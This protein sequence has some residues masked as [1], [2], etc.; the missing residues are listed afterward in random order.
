MKRWLRRTA[1][2]VVVALVG[3]TVWVVGQREYIRR[4]GESAFAASAAD[5]EATD[6][7]WRWDDLAAKRPRPPEGRNGMDV[8]MRAREALPLDWTTQPLPDAW[9]PLDTPDPPTAKLDPKVAAAARER[10]DA[11]GAGLVL[12]RS[13]KDCPTGLYPLVLADPP[14][15]T[16]F[17]HV[18]AARLV[19]VFLRWDAAVA[20][21]SGDAAAALDRCAAQLN[22]SRALGDDPFMIGQL[23]RVQTRATAW[24]A[25]ERVLA[26]TTSD[27]ARLAAL[28]AAWAAD[29][30]EPLLLFAARGERAISDRT[31]ENMI[32]G[33]TKPDPRDF[34][35]TWFGS[36]SWWLAR[37][38]M[39]PDRAALHEHMSKVVAAA[40]RPV[41]EQPAAFA[42]LPPPP[43]ERQIA[44]LLAPPLDRLA[45]PY[46]RS[47][48]QARCVVVALA[49]ERYR[50]RTGRWPDALG[51]LPP[52]LL[53]AV[54]LDP[55][56]G[57]PLR[58]RRTA[59]GVVVYTVG[60]DRRD[61]GGDVAGADGPD[62][63]F[64]LWN[65][66]LRGQ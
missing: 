9:P 1:A 49:C 43:A 33:V 18:E 29:A 20:A 32:T 37:G 41:H 25:L 36:Y 23:V 7:D 17:P 31:I 55:L 27:P 38:K 3:R 15:S 26:Q 10:L 28:Q 12:A 2:L 24:R 11:G 16:R 4:G 64:R 34:A 56:D 30:E 47:V 46:W 44:A 35:G 45:T 60:R 62:D 59:D 52:D 6:P 14:I 63:G 57:Q 66:E 53:A 22:L 19:A 13:L 39:W 40:R 61:D 50:Q 58:F 51:A 5:A 8:A 54:P 48:G 21:D 42:A 65:P